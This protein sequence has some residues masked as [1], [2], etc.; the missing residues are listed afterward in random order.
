MSTDN[1]MWQREQVVGLPI[2]HQGIRLTPQSEAISLRWSSGV[3]S[4][5]A[6]IWHR[7]TALLVEQEGETSHIPIPD[8][9]RQVQI[10]LWGLA[11]FFSLIAWLLARRRASKA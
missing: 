1:G 7:P 11:T 10:A 4:G 9:T 5:F 8:V 3:E 2:T 6:A